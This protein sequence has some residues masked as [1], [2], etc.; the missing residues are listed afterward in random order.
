[1][2]RA[3]V[4]LGLVSA[5]S[6]GLSSQ[7][8]AA[9]RRPA[10]DGLQV[11]VITIGQGALYFEKYGHN[12]LW[13]YDPAAGI[14]HAFNWGSF[15]FA[16][17]GFLRRQMIGDPQYRVDVYA[18]QPTMD[19]YRDRDRSIVLQRLN[20]TAA[21]KRKALEHAMWNAREENRY[22]RYDYYRDNCSTRVRD[23]IDLALGGSLK[24]STSTEHVPLTYRSETTRLLDD[25][26]LIQFGVNVALGRPA[27]RPLSIWESMFIPMRMRDAL[28]KVRV[29][30]S[31][32][33]QT[34]LVADE[35]VVYESTQ[36]AERDDVPRL[37]PAYLIIGL[38][39]AA[40]LIAAAWL[41]RRSSAADK[42]FRFEVALW[43]LIAGLLGVILLLGWLIT[44]H[45]FWYQ[46]ENLLFLNPLSLFLMVLA[47]L[48]I[49]RPRWLRPAAI[50]AVI[51]AMLGAVALMLK[52]LPG[53]SQQNLALL[54]LFVPAHFAAAYG[55]WSSARRQ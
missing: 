39:I 16:A 52:G 18:G 4:A 34:P 40:E 3:F 33:V 46:N 41:G 21:Q 14:D 37:W 32:G 23:V 2:K 20:L 13:F 47:P 8:P 49:W 31:T 42:A 45:V 10:G 24:A 51:V 35:R 25:L 9:S 43:S 19:A 44:Q 12:M 6:A 54:L 55:L 7:P 17:P 29:T 30:D 38:L 5:L 22:Y 11:F 28:R 27:N 50:C 26:K 36:Y 53:L 48:S 15:D 1:V